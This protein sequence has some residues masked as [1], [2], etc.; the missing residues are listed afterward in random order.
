MCKSSAFRLLTIVLTA[1]GFLLSVQGCAYLKY[2]ADDFAEIVDIGFTISK[3]PYFALY[4]DELSFLPLGYAHVDGHF[5]G[6]GGGQVGKTTHSVHSW[7]VLVHGTEELGW[8][9]KYEG[10]G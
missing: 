4:A 3:K 2:R 9:R 1:F 10:E 7:G 5:I 8:H 6:W